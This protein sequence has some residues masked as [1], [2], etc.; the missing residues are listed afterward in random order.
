LTSDP[1]TDFQQNTKAHLDRRMT[2]GKPEVLTVKGPTDTA[3]RS[4]AA[5]DRLK[6][7]WRRGERTMNT[8]KNSTIALCLT[9][10]LAF[11]PVAS[12]AQATT[13]FSG[14]AVAL[15]GNALGISLALSDTGPLAASGGNLNTSLASVNVLGLAS[16]HALKSTTSGSGTS[17]PTYIAIIHSTDGWNS[18]P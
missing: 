2:T 13:T 11:S 17:I 9:A 1:L 8:K 14:E 12:F 18:L 4:C 5:V 15:R 6:L 3:A 16:A 10:I 7:N